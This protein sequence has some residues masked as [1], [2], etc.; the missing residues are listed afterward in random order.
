MKR[1][2]DVIVGVVVIVITAL[3]IFATLWANQAELGGH[4]RKVIARFHDVGNAKV[5]ND[6]VIRGVRAGRIEAI[7][8]APSGWVHVR[9]TLLPDVELPH[10]PV[11]LLSESSVFGE[12]QAT[13]A[14]RAAAPRDRAVAQQLPESSGGGGDHILPG[15]T[16]PDIAKLTAVAGQIAGDVANVAAR[17]QTAFD[18]SA[19]RELRGSIRNVADLSA[20]M[21]S[22]VREHAGDIDSLSG[23]LHVAVRSLNRTAE[24][25]ARMTA[26]FDTATS[27]G[28][29]RQMIADVAASAADLRVATAQVRIMTGALARSQG[30]LD[31]LLAASSSVMARIDAGQGTLGM[32]V[33]DPAMYR[34]GDSLLVEFRELVADIKANPKRYVNVKVF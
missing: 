19:A 6:V 28:A 29:V 18:D 15:A 7:E 31:T 12:W 22:T 16:L 33:N 8:L 34:H 13:V 10:D 11:V 26:R 25:V 20:T 1:R 9:M 32:F 17:V 2:S 27:T 3:T 4:R 14:D 24:N 21:S 30:R 5:G 23:Q